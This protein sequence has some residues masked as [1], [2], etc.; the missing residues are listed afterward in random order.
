M[1][2]ANLRTKHGPEHKIQQEIIQF[3]RYREWLVKPTHGTMF[4][5]G[6]PDLFAT[7]K[8]YGSR[9][10]EVKNPL[11]YSFTPAQLEWFPQFVAHGTGIWILIA[12][13]EAEYSKLFQ[14]CN[15]YQYLKF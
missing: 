15:W 2:R 7:H 4:Q 3:L 8:R 11:K 10:I 1:D 9:W 13:T 14:D 5:C 12:A 6:F